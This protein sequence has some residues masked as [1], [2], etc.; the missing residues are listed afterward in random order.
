M[1]NDE[2]TLVPRSRTAS[3]FR[4]IPPV[5]TPVQRTEPSAT[6]AP[7]PMS[8]EQR[9]PTWDCS[10]RPAVR[11]ARERDRATPRRRMVAGLGS[12]G[13]FRASVLTRRPKRW[14]SVRRCLLKALHSCQSIQQPLRARRR[15]LHG[16]RRQR[17]LGLACSFLD[18]AAHQKPS[19]GS[20]VLISPSARWRDFAGDTGLQCPTQERRSPAP[21]SPPAACR[22]RSSASRGP[23]PWSLPC[24]PKPGVD[25]APAH[26]GYGHRLGGSTPPVHG[27]TRSVG[28]TLVCRSVGPRPNAVSRWEPN[29]TSKAIAIRVAGD[30]TRSTSPEMGAGSADRRAWR[31]R[32]PVRLA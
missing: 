17:L 2:G 29:R 11:P 21:A 22:R 8:R 12:R 27:C 14:T 10:L 3:T 24:D 7:W 1:A 16:G 25:G 9:T 30:R 28:W 13:A 19:R 32:H 20:D 5:G 6:S 4:R 18:A 23:R 26:A 31:G 15:K